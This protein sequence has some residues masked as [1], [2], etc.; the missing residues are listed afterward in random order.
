M[1]DDELPPIVQETA[2]EYPQVWEAYNSLGQALGK[3]GPLDANT[4]RLVKLAIA[5]GANLEVVIDDT[6]FTRAAVEG[7][8]GD[9]IAA[10]VITGLVLLFFLHT[11]NSAAIVVMTVP[12]AIL[13]TFLGMAAF[14][15]T[16]N[17]LTLLALM[18]CGG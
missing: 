5:V 8:Q 2:A 6:L 11:V 9:L 7:V 3:A 17:T 10:I 4:E 14:G 13:I 1:T 12:V 18:V 15:F 16:L